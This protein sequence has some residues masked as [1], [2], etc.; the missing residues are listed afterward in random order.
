MKQ[1]WLLLQD[2]RKTYLL[3]RDQQNYYLILVDRFLTWETEEWLIDHGISK[4]RLEELPL[5]YETLPR[6]QLRGIALTGTNAGDALYLYPKSGKRR[7]YTFSDDCSEE[8]IDVFFAGVERYLAPSEQ[9][10]KSSDTG[11]WRVDL[12][13]PEIFRK[14]EYVCI[15][16]TVL[17]TLFALGYVWNQGVFWYTALL[18]ANGAAVALTILFPQYFTLLPD[19]KNKKKSAWNMAWSLN[20]QLIVSIALPAR[21]WL[22]DSLFW[23]SVFIC[24]TVAAAVLGLLSEEFKRAKIWLLAVF[25]FVGVLGHGTV[26]HINEV[27]DFSEP[28][29]C[30]LVVEEL[31]YHKSRR[32]S[33]YECTV[34]LPDGRQV[35][36]DISRNFYRTLKV[37]DPVRVEV[38]TGALGIEYAN[39]YPVE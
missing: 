16:V 15:G 3:A 35:E 39:A 26:G 11:D 37:G 33:T 2:G 38:G 24:G 12:Q 23:P 31:D 27:Y 9:K 4:E 19:E 10:K 25:L 29:S 13:D 36:L 32:S 30:I 22:D 14:M 34:T 18:L 20:S 8:Q 28:E 17:S 5:N 1:P 7:H 21:N 6:K